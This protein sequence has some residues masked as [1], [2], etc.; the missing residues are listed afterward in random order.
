MRPRRLFPLTVPACLFMP[1]VIFAQ[2]QYSVH[3]LG[4]LGANFNFN[5]QATGINN[6]GQVVGNSGSHAFRTA[7]NSAINPATDD[8]GTLCINQVCSF[9]TYATGINSS[10]QVVGSNEFLFLTRGFR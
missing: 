6:S 7:A 4:T 3:D 5:R 1:F 9:P 2:S 8:L 10:G